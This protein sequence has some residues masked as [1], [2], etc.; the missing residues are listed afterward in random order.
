MHLIVDVS[1]TLQTP[2]GNE[3]IT[4]ELCFHSCLVVVFL[5]QT[6]ELQKKEEC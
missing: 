6:K 1:G 2:A 5:S 4:F 3:L